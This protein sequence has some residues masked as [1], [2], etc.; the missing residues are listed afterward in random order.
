MRPLALALVLGTLAGAA[1][2]E[3][4]SFKS[5]PGRDGANV[6]VRRTSH[7]IPHILGPQLPRRRLR[8]RLRV[9]PGQHLHRS[10]SSYVT[11]RAERSR[12]FGP[13]ESWKFEGNGTTV[14]NL[15][16]DFFFKR[17]NDTRR[18]RSGCSAAA[19]RTARCREVREGVRGYVAGY[20]RYLRDTGRGPHPRPDL[21]RQAVGAADPRDR[22]LPLLLQARPA[23]QLG[24]GHRRDRRRAAADPGAAVGRAARSAEQLDADQ[25]QPR[26]LLARRRWAATRTASAGRPPRSGRGMVLGNPHFPW[27]GSQRFYQSHLT[28]P[29]KADVAGASLFGVPIVLIGHTQELRLEPHGLHRAPLHAVRAQ[30][31]PRLA[32]LVPLRRPD[33]ADEGRPGDGRGSRAARGRGRCTRRVHGPVV[34][35]DPR[36]CRCS[37]GRPRRRH[38]MGDVNAANFRYLNHFLE[39]NMTQSVRQYDRVQRRNQGIPWVN[40]IAADSTRRGLLRRHRGDPQRPQREGA[41]VQHRARARRPRP[42]RAADPRRLA[43][44]VPSGAPTPTP[45]SPARSARATCRACSGATT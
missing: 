36:A 2:A 44:G 35:L 22:R 12:F 27:Q 28:I 14:N 32:D 15:N 43:H 40:S 24:R 33:P 26:P 30:A 45:S 38:A 25:G 37:P 7:G 29:G 11:V 8:L 21:P 39:T 3:A 5:L 4:A 23:G 31:G 9:R 41:P 19:R 42:A 1:N 6:A 10:P 18:G 13:D 16:S 17:I 20:N 34:H